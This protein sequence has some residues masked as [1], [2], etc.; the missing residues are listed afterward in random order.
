MDVYC[1]ICTLTSSSP[2]TLNFVL[3]AY[4]DRILLKLS[5][6]HLDHTEQSCSPKRHTVKADMDMEVNLHV[7]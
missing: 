4:A 5:E 7:F 3:P 1:Y 2:C 6:P